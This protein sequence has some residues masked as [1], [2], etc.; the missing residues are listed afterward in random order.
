MASKTVLTPAMM[1]VW[2]A[3][4]DN[5]RE[6]CN[7]CDIRYYPFT[8]QDVRLK[9]ASVSQTT[10]NTAWRRLIERRWIGLVNQTRCNNKNLFIMQ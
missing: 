3:I 9:V 2:S 7:D 6:E 1:R 10:F 4:V 8:K 5:Y